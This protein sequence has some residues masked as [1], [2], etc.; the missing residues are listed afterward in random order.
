MF[1]IKPCPECGRKLRFPLDKGVIRVKCLCGF[2]FTADPDN[3]SLYENAV[4]D[5]K[6]P[7]SRRKIKRTSGTGF[8]LRTNLKKIFGFLMERLLM[9]KYTLQNFRLLPVERQRKVIIIMIICAAAL[10]LTVCLL[11]SL[12]GGR[13]HQNGIIL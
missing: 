9:I 2:S 4:F 5:L 1:L 6:T 13:A 8:S 12:S 7:G 11:I 3:P 10:I